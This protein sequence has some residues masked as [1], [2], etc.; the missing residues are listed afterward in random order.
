MAKTIS[1]TTVAAMVMLPGEGKSQVQNLLVNF[2]M[3]E[4]IVPKSKGQIL[5]AVTDKLL[6]QQAEEYVSMYCDYPPAV[7]VAE[8]SSI[9]HWQAANKIVICDE[10]DLMINDYCAIAEP[11]STVPRVKGLVSLKTAKKVVI[12]TGINDLF[13]MGVLRT[14]FGVN[15]DDVIEVKS[16]AS[17]QSNNASNLDQQ[18]TRLT[19]GDMNRALQ[20]VASIVQQVER[21]VVLFIESGSKSYD[22]ALA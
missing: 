5:L 8:I 22:K 16:V 14:V 21:P 7:E 15:D 9:D 17:L 2:L 11:E 13:H 19:A 6:L 12:M 20:K 3:Q 1:K 18:I 10:G 4:K